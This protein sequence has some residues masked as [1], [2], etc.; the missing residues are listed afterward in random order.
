[1]SVDP[2]S[3]GI[4]FRDAA[5]WLY[6]CGFGAILCDSGW[7]WNL[8]DPDYE[9]VCL[10]EVVNFLQTNCYG[11]SDNSGIIW[12][13]PDQVAEDR[14]IANSA[15]DPVILPLATRMHVKRMMMV[16]G[17]V[18]RRVSNLVFVDGSYA[19]VFNLFDC[20]RQDGSARLQTELHMMM[21]HIM[22]SMPQHYA[23]GALDTYFVRYP[24]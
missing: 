20:V 23:C 15:P 4:A 16:N 3:N 12:R 22:W 1:M 14:I 5:L 6:D 21:W 18:E 7:D 9:I 11:C 8:K 17:V 13:L 10:G 2:G 19:L 24:L